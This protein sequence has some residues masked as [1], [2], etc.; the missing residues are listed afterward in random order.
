MWWSRGLSHRILI[1][2]IEIYLNIP[3]N[4]DTCDPIASMES[5][6]HWLIY[7]S[8]STFKLLLFLQSLLY[9]HVCVY[10]FNNSVET[11]TFSH[12]LHEPLKWSNSHCSD[13]YMHTPNWT[14]DCK[15][16]SW[17][18]Q[19]NPSHHNRLTNTSTIY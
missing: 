6:L 7:C 1:F 14:I 16:Y 15:L 2:I 19:S 3:Y 11:L 10:L 17:Y 5:N 18:T 8:D 12:G 9:M 13:K 4:M